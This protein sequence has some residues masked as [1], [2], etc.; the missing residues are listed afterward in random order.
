MGSEKRGNGN[1]VCSTLRTSLSSEMLKHRKPIQL[2]IYN[3]V[4]FKEKD[5]FCIK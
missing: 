3:C 2:F 5:Y 4:D 1:G